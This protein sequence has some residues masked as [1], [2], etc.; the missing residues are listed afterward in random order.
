MIVKRGIKKYSSVWEE[1]VGDKEGS[2][3]P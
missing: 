3:S 1:A 2:L